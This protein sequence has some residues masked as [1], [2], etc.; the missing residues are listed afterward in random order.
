MRNTSIPPFRMSTLNLSGRWSS[1]LFYR[2]SFASPTFWAQIW[3]VLDVRYL[4][5]FL[6]LKMS[7]MLASTNL[8]S[9]SKWNT[10]ILRDCFH[11]VQQ[12]CVVAVSHHRWRRVA[13]LVQLHPFRL[14]NPGSNLNHSKRDGGLA[15]R[16]SVFASFVQNLLCSGTM[17]AIQNC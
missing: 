9:Y 14:L 13:H 12:W 4:D 11:R 15:G 1:S 3:P 2:Y 10:S 8:T 5:D 17:R 16:Q 6:S 7:L